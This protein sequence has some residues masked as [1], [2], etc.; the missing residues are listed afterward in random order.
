MPSSIREIAA[1]ELLAG[2]TRIGDAHMHARALPAD[3]RYLQAQLGPAIA[4]HRVTRSP[5]TRDLRLH[6][7]QGSIA[8]SDGG[9]SGRKRERQ[10]AGVAGGAKSNLALS[11]TSGALGDCRNR[12]DILVCDNRG[13][14]G[15]AQASA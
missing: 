15:S 7:V 1:A 14:C 11:S 9:V 3:S 13:W 4:N 8:F 6:R 10:S 2:R 5:L 12:D